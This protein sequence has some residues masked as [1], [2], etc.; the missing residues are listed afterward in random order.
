M[1]KKHVLDE[2][3]AESPNRRSFLTKLAMAGAAVTA[4]GSG[5][6]LAKAQSATLTDADIL[7][8]AL[9]L[10]Y[11]EA[12]FY[13]VATTGKT[14]D[15]M[16]VGI[17]GSGTAGATTGGQLVNLDNTTIF[18]KDI[19]NQIA[20]DERA[21]VT[22]I[23]GALKA[24]GAVPVAK[25]AINLGA[26]GFGFGATTDFLQLARSFE[27]VGVTAYAG[28]APL[29]SDKGIL[30]YAARIAE[31][32]SAHSA[33][34][35]LQIARLGISTSLLDGADVLPPP[36]GSKYFPVD[37]NGLT[38]TRT[39]GQVLFLV[40]GFK[41]NVTSGGFFPNGF[42]GTINTSSD[43]VSTANITNASVNP[44]TTTTNQAMITLD[45]GGSTSASGKL[46]YFFMVKPGGKVPAILQTSDNP[47]ATI[48]FVNGA[49]TYPLTLTVT[50]GAGKTSST[51]IMLIYMP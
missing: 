19:A 7:N 15:Q 44:S 46:T 39:P 36:S 17:D 40:Y 43:G 26:L 27:D 18:T 21:H 9:N 30:G 37:S 16:G 5:V 33:N 41:A 2:I 13:T 11:L 32:E 1:A 48:Q 31:V 3:V 4:V 50:D 12:E 6:Q 14:I 47:K 34:I 8:F 38:Q 23:R 25:P 49:G 10:E 35:R 29:I 45:A 20:A 22:L 28:A 42:N 24:A 51:D